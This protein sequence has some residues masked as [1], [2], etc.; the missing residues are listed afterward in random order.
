MLLA[1]DQALLVYSDS[2]STA[3]IAFNQLSVSLLT[4]TPITVKL[5]RF[6]GPKVQD[7]AKM[8]DF[9]S[10]LA[11]ASVQSGLSRFADRARHGLI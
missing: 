11:Y 5:V 3:E 8:A 6:F 1:L 4:Q 10:A 2:R 9:L 7:A